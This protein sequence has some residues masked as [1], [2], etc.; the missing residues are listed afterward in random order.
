MPSNNKKQPEIL[1]E[2]DLVSAIKGKNLSG[3]YCIFGDEQYLIKRHINEM[4]RLAVSDLADLNLMKFDG[5]VKAQ[6]VYDAVT[7]FP[8][9]S[10]S[11]AVTLCDFPFDKAPQ[12]E[13]DKLFSAIADMPPTTVFIIWFE[14]ISIP[15]K[16]PG[17]RFSKLFFAVSES[18][19][20]VYNIGRKNTSDIM[21]L[22]QSGAARRKCR[23]EPTTARYMIDT[24]SDDLSTLVNELEKLCLYVGEGGNISNETVDLVCSRSLEASVYSLSKAVLRGDIAGAFKTIDDLSFMNTDPAYILTILSSAYIDIYRA[25]AAKCAGIRP[26]AAAKELGYFGTA[27][28]LTDAERQLKNFSEKQIISSLRCLYECDKTVKSSRVP[29]RTTLEKAVVQLALIARGQK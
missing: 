4:L 29:G 24:C 26:E 16:K 25:Y 27:F 7:S 1:T 20:H 5:A 22:L 17:D 13:I 28:R 15:V 3:C 14:T 6:T 19:G 10:A 2:N 18:G 21:R 9:M 23:M 11:R 8:V 12:N